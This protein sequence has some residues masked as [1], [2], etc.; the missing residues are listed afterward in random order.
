M[1]FRKEK[2]YRLTK[3]DFYTFKSHIASMG[4][5]PLY[6]KRQINSVYFDTKHMQMFHDSEEG[7]LPRKKIRVR[8]YNKS[9]KYSKEIKISSIEGRFKS[10]EKLTAIKKLNNISGMKFFD[11]SYG[12][13]YPI[14]KISYLRTYFELDDMRITFDENISYKDLR[15]DNC[16]SRSDA[17]CVVEVKIPDSFAEDSLEKII[18]YQISRFSKFCTGILMIEKQLL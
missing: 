14:I 8:W 3:S 9:K 7:V 10:S 16:N 2:K 5:K 17:E 4:M 6:D 13:V 12:Y 18:P 11:L 1:S 15:K